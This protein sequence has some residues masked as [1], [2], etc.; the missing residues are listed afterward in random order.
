MCFRHEKASRIKCSDFKS[1]RLCS[2]MF[3]TLLPWG[4]LDAL[5]DIHGNGSSSFYLSAWPFYL[6]DILS[7][8]DVEAVGARNRV[9][10]SL[11][12]QGFIM[13]IRTWT[14]TFSSWAKGSSH[15]SRYPTPTLLQTETGTHY[16]GKHGVA[17]A[18]CDN[19]D[20]IIN[21]HSLDHLR[22]ESLGSVNFVF[23]SSWPENMHKCLARDATR[24]I[25]RF[26]RSHKVKAR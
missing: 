2:R 4:W 17:V 8:G 26:L 16:T 5:D 18:E 23:W 21:A 24:L 1:D 12:Q 10:S 14:Q 3:Y 15:W 19:A 11:S 20:N 22:A 6:K 9:R 25:K 13:I 7:L